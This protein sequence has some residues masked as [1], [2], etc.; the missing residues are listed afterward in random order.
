MSFAVAIAI[1]LALI[2]IRLVGVP[3]WLLSRDV[4]RDEPRIRA[5]F[6]GLQGRAGPYAKVV[7]ID[8]DGRSLGSAY[9]SPTRRYRVEVQL[10]TGERRRMEVSIETPLFGGGRLWEKKA[11]P[12]A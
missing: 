3:L 10:A 12:E 6:E 8:E 7:K 1:I 11:D 2:L 5:E 9:A 4:E